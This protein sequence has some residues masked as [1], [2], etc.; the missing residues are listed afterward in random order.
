MKTLRYFC[1]FNIFD[2]QDNLLTWALSHSFNLI[3]DE[4]SPDIVLTGDDLNPNLLNY[5]N[6]KI[7]YYTG[8]PFLSWSGDIDRKI[9]DVALTFF[10]FE[11]S[12]FK[13]V[14]LALFYNYEYYK[15]QYIDDYEYLLK[16]K[17]SLVIPDKFCSFVTRGYGYPS[18]PRKHIFEQLSSYKYINSHGSYFNNSPQ[19]PIGNTMKF[20]N[21]LFKVKEISNYKFNICFENSD[22]CVKSPNDFTYVSK[23]GLLSEKIY[24]SLLSGTIPIYWGNK[25]IDKDLNTNRFINYY[26]YENFEHMI[27]KVKEIDNDD[28]MYLEYKNENFI[29][30]NKNSIF[31]K[32]YIIELMKNIAY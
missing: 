26:D 22:G 32:C 19:I 29:S 20:E 5:K 30:N 11:D 2:R 14:P 21:S 3:F 16:N 28:K 6:S 23:S 24:E 9:I 25:D 7:I 8:E 31:S 10:N 1:D 13:R 18:C 17:S 15:N 4:V 12:F 27:E